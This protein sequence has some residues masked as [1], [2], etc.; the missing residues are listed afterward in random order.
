MCLADATRWKHQ[1]GFHDRG[2]QWDIPMSTWAGEVEDW[3]QLM[4]QGPRRKGDVTICFL[5]AADGEKRLRSGAQKK[6]RHLE[7]LVLQRSAEDKK[8]MLKIFSRI[9]QRTDVW[10]RKGVKD[11][12]EEWIDVANVVRPD[13]VGLCGFGIVVVRYVRSGDYD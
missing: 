5:E 12:E 3:K 11:L 10:V 8:L 2:V 13:D 9:H 7:P 6:T 4:A 1:F